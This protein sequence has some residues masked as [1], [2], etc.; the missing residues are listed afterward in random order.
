M[1]AGV[2]MALHSRDIDRANA[3]KKWLSERSITPA[4]AYAGGA[5]LTVILVAGALPSV[6]KPLVMTLVG[7]G[8]LAAVFLYNFRK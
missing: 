2:V 6:I 3:I 1:P 5:L 8:I 4:K 7:V